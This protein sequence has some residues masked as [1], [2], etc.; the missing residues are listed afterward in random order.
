MKKK[1]I[2]PFWRAYSASLLGFIR[3]LRDKFPLMNG[4]MPFHSPSS[5]DD[6]RKK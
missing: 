2:S 1:V 6:E 5:L 3:F 4:D